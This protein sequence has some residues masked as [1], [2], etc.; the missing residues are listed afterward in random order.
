MAYNEI[1]AERIRRALSGL[2]SVEERRMFGGVAFMVGSK[3]CLTAGADRMM[4]R[5]DPDIHEEAT[6]KA[7]CHT[8]VM[9][10]RKYK[11]YV[12]INENS[13]QT[14]SDFDYWVGLALEFNKKVNRLPQS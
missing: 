10:G 3:M 5:I 7:G 13:L 1:L 8:V 2:P 9:R 4:C 12:Y 14:Q 11:G 6:S